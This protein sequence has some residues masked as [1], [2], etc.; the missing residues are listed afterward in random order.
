MTTH[1]IARALGSRHGCWAQIVE[2]WGLLA[3]SL[4]L[5]FLHSS[6][7]PLWALATLSQAPMG[8]REILT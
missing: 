5:F 2:V 8:W 3:V 1:C 6:L 4:G 7:E